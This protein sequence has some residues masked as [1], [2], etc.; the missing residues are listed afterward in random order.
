MTHPDVT[1][2]QQGDED[3][4]CEGDRAVQASLELGV[5]DPAG[6]LKS[7]ISPLLGS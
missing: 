5:D 1:V 6:L 7:P 4:G 3:V 2:F